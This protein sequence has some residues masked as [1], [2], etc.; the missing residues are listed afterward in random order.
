LAADPTERKP[1]SRDGY[2][3]EHLTIG[4]SRCDLVTADR[5]MTRIARERD[6][7]PDGC[8]LFEFS[9]VAGLTAVV[10]QALGS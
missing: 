2:D 1:R 7:I 10:E 4:L 8:Q 5:S 3:I 6:L 9:D